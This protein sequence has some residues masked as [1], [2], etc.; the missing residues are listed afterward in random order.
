LDA[1]AGA[2]EVTDP[3]ASKICQCGHLE[4]EHGYKVR[5]IVRPF[6][7]IQSCNCEEFHVD[8]AI[9]EVEGVCKRCGG[10]GEEP[11]SIRDPDY[12][13]NKCHDCGGTGESE[14][15]EMPK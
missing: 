4:S 9:A 1:G 2:A 10:T 12:G 11:G 5:G 15:V 3:I 8:D 14:E 7:S 6:C 13:I